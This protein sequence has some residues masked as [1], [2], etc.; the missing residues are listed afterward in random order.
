MMH[1]IVI[2]AGDK[3]P[4]IGK[5]VDDLQTAGFDVRVLNSATAKLVDFL[6]AIAGADDDDADDDAASTKDKPE[7]SENVAPEKE[8][9]KEPKDEPPADEPVDDEDPLNPAKM[10]AMVNGEKVNIRIVEGGDVTLHPSTIS[11]GAKT[12]YSLNESQYSF[13]PGA[14]SNEPISGGVELSLNGAA[15]EQLTKIVFSEEAMS[16]PTLCVGREWLKEHYPASQV[17]TVK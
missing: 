10:E 2:I 14:V 4:A 11:I 15:V 9:K 5:A 17:L 16:P 6:G 1:P 7:N 12:F 3:D 8:P 13:W